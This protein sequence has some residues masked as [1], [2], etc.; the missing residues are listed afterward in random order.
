MHLNGG[1]FLKYHLKGNTCRKWTN[2]LKI[3]DSENILTPGVGLPHSG[4]IYIFNI[5]FKD[6]IL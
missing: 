6:L 5:I 1:K 2:G 4:A 3:C